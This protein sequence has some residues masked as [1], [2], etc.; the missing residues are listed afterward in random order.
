MTETTYGGWLQ[1]TD[2]GRPSARR[3][4]RIGEFL[5]ARFYLEVGV[6]RGKTF[7]RLKFEHKVAVDPRF[8]FDTQEFAAEGVDF[9]DGTSDDFFASKPA[10]ELFDVVFLDGMHTFHQTLKDFV[11]SMACSHERTVW[12]IDDVIPLDYYGSLPD[13]GHGI[14]L[15]RSE[16]TATTGNWTGDVYKLMFAIHDFFPALNYVVIVGGG[17][18]QMLIWKEGRVG[19]KPILDSLEAIDRLSYADFVRLLPDL[20]RVSEDEA[21]AMLAASFRSRYPVEYPHHDAD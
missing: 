20:N 16:T 10:S 12:L 13:Q 1:G 19:Y 9:F 2:A 8:R 14:K 18:E 21:I 15:R 17:P 7:N 6:N 4:A 3:I 5:R 11:C